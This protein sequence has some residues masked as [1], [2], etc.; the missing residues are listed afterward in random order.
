ML[1]SGQEATKP[2][3]KREQINIVV[4]DENRKAE[5]AFKCEQRLLVKYMKY[6]QKF[7]D[8]ATKSSEIDITVH[9]DIKIFEWLI[10]Y[11]HQRERIEKSNLK[12]VFA[13]RHLIYRKKTEDEKQKEKATEAL[14]GSDRVPV[15]DLKNVISILISADF[16][17][18]NELVRECIAYV[19]SNLHDVVRLPID[20]NCL[21]DKVL[22]L[23]AEQLPIGKL[24]NLA[25]KR[26]KLTS[27]LFKAK[28]EQLL[29]A[30][31]HNQIDGVGGRNR[32]IYCSDVHSYLWHKVSN[33]ELTKSYLLSKENLKIEDICFTVD[34]YKFNNQDLISKFSNL[35]ELD[36]P[37]PK[38]TSK[39][40][41]L[42]AIQLCHHCD[43]LFVPGN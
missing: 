30:V 29:S 25:D 41:K 5:K 9:C 20:M 19:I 12:G 3:L 22:Y 15:L 31:T 43:C 13:A 42:F 40:Q 33:S 2:L 27:R 21:S 38:A 7:L 37:K 16:L 26:D 8:Q 34:V 28:L 35:I 24:N 14:Q 36:P 4:F 10:Q 23:I 1:S 39:P 18:I 6:F 17:I 11:M 32:P